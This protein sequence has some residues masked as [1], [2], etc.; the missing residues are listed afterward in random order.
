MIGSRLGPYE[1]TAKLGEGGMGEVYRATDTKLKRDVAIKVLPAAFTEDRERLARFEREAQLLAQLHHPNI[2]SIFG[3]EESDGRRALVMELVEGPTL[4]ERLE[5]GLLP[6]NESLSIAVQI[7]QALEEAHEKGIVH[8][9]LKPQ[10]IKASIEGKVKVLDFGLAKAMDATASGPASASQLAHSPTITLGATAQGVILGTAAYMAPEQA[11][12][13]PVDK[14][15]DI[16]AF[17]VVLYEML[18]G[19]GAFHADTV[20]DTLAAVLTR[21]LDWSALPASTPPAMRRLL[22]RCLE[23]SPKNRLHDVADARIVL[24]ELVSGRADDGPTASAGSL[25]EAVPPL[26]RAA[27][28]N[29]WLLLVGVALV[30]G[31]AG[32]LVGRGPLASPPPDPPRLVSLTYSG[33]DGVPS[34][35]PDGKTIAFESLRDGQSRIWIKQLSTGEE[36]ALTAGP[37]DTKPAFSPDGSSLLFLRGPAPPFELYRVSSVG[38]QPRRIAEGIAS[39]ATWSPDG[40]RI[41]L[42]RSS[43]ISGLPD[44]LVLRAVEGGEER[45]LARPSDVNLLGL[46]WSPDGRSIGAWSQLRSNFAAQ[47]SIVEFDAASGAR[48]TLYQPGGGVLLGGWSWSGPDAIV[49]SEAITQSGR[50]GSRLRRVSIASGVA[51]TLVSLRQPSTGLDVVGAGQVVV[52]QVA[53]PQNLTEVPLDGSEAP[54]SREARHWLTRGEIVDRQPVYS[55]DGKRLLFNSD[56]GGNLDLWELERSSG[57]VRPVTDAAADDWDPAYTPDGSRIL[58]SSNRSGNFEIWTAAADGS[59]PRQLTRDGVDAENPT[60][61]PDG[62]WIVY[63]SANPEHPGVWKIRADGTAAT[64]VVAGTQ[65]VTQISP[66]GRWVSFVDLD[67]NRLRVV[68]LED[69]LEITTIELPTNTFNAF[70]V[71]RSRWLPGSSTLMWIDYDS[72]T[73]TSSIVAQEVVAGR[74]TRATR[75]TLVRGLPDESPESFDVS[76]DGTHLLISVFQPRSELLLVQGLAGVHR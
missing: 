62:Q 35:S 32:M 56:R 74:D 9:D 69:G 5:Q 36:V 38:G 31:T 54:A 16:W 75:R 64:Q 63:N 51:T 30:A 19:Q 46:R 59:G 61:T 66:D 41:A 4:A 12:G 42:T 43:T 13:L 44:I 24:E 6:F 14:R 8:R 40:K 23:R 2:A 55:P 26:P 25:P 58:W 7:A 67:H 52:D 27:R 60:A 33:R 18:T 39:S 49:V 20:P 34:S 48:R 57:A 37:Y 21:E 70:Q 29:R 72:L 17:G 22:R 3:L 47:Q 50:G 71:G 28:V 15:A 76:P 53:P 11:R 73:A 68:A 65:T 1:I 45:E 10:N